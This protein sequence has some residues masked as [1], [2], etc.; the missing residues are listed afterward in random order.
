MVCG[1]SGC[2]VDFDNDNFKPQ[3]SPNSF[4]NPSPPA[5]KVI[6]SKVVVDKQLE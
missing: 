3:L 5:E 4:K 1:W 6:P 2:K